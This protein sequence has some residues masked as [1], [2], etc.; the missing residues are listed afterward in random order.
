[1]V[2][3]FLIYGMAGWVL[4]VGFTGLGSLVK[5]DR[6][7]TAKTYLWMLPI[8]GGTA[9]AME[10]LAEKLRRTPRVLRALTYLG[11]IYL[12]EYT[13]GALLKK[14]LGRCPWDYGCEGKTVAGLIRLDYAPFWLALALAFEPI[15]EVAREVRLVKRTSWIR[16][17]LPAVLMSA[18]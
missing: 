4:E 2:Q 16:G 11:V 13:S 18:R 3:R 17:L 10:V 7:L 15:R 14:V 9:L 8:Y 6:T 12:A 1:M 5:K